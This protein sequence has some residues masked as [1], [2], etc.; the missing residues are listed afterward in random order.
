MII[1]DDYIQLGT[2]GKPFQ[3]KGGLHFYPL[4]DAEAEAILSLKQVSIEA[5]GKVD[6]RRVEKVGS[7]LIIYLTRALSPEAARSFVNRD[8]YAARGVLPARDE[9]EIYIDELI[10]QLVFLG[11]EPYGNVLEVLDADMQDIL[12][13]RVKTGATVLIPLQAPYVD[14]TDDGV[15]L[16]D[17]PDGLLDLNT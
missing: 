14:V 10:G 3:L 4:G 6:V 1:P 15:Y 13:I 9:T 17:V 16:K 11:A 12:R 8:V 5:I 2:L 7:K